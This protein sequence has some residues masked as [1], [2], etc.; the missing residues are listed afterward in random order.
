MV[1]LAP[2]LA[3]C[4][5]VCTSAFVLLAGPPAKAQSSEHRQRP[6]QGLSKEHLNKPESSAMRLLTSPVSTELPRALRASRGLVQ[7]FPNEEKR[8]VDAEAMEIA[9]GSEAQVPN[10]VAHPWS[11]GVTAGT[12][13]GVGGSVG[14][15]FSKS[16]GVRALTGGLGFNIPI[17]VEGEVN[18][19]DIDYNLGGTA[20]LVDWH[21]WKN[22]W[23]L[24]LGLA[25]SQ[26][27]ITAAASGKDSGGIAYNSQ[28]DIEYPSSALPFLSIGRIWGRQNSRWSFYLESGYVFRGTPN[29]SLSGSNDDCA[30]SVSKN[31]QAQLAETC[32][33]MPDDREE[34]VSA[35]EDAHSEIKSGIEKY[36]F[37]LN[38]TSNLGI[39]YR[40]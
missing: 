3:R 32:G 25:L 31:G 18:V 33:G 22:P 2:R 4:A 29:V 26:N 15:D 8:A 10:D 9:Q 35:L 12:L 28:Y 23:R 19:G 1:F 6:D 11:V 36:G 7:M 24:S 20:L 5:A 27:K 17:D 16:F 21:P 37:L 13:A 40:F 30:F 34:F 38:F 14:F 39:L